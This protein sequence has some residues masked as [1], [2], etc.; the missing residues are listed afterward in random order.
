MRIVA[1]FIFGTLLA[2]YPQDLGAS[3]ADV[4]RRGEQVQEEA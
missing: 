4:Y 1:L 3:L 2:R